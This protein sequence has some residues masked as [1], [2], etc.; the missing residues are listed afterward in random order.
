MKLVKVIWWDAADPANGPWHT[1]QELDAFA[2]QKVEVHSY[3]LLYKKTKAYVTLIGDL[4]IT[5]EAGISGRPTKIPLKMVKSIITL[6]D[7]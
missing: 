3:G 1:P 6:G 4:I 7:A 5:G 2:D